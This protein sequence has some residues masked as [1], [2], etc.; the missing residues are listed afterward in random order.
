MN[1]DTLRPIKIDYEQISLDLPYPS[2]YVFNIQHSADVKCTVGRSRNV[3][4]EGFSTF[5]DG[6][7]F[8]LLQKHS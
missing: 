1:M 7:C 3:K 8:I 2:R 6:T 4:D 5:G